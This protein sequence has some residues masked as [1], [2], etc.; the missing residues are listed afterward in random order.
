M[1]VAGFR[2]CLFTARSDA[3]YSNDRDGVNA[4]G[5]DGGAGDA[6]ILGQQY[7]MPM[8]KFVAGWC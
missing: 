6:G 2:H 1:A 5:F 7:G 8:D 4:T 3:V